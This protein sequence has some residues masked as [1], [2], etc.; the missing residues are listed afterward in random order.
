ME[1]RSAVT[2]ELMRERSEAKQAVEEQLKKITDERDALQ[3]EL[4]RVELLH[5]HELEV[6]RVSVKRAADAVQEQYDRGFVNGLK[7][8]AEAYS[9]SPQKNGDDQRN[10]VK[11]R[12]SLEEAA[13]LEDGEEAKE[14]VLVVVLE[15]LVN[16]PN[17]YTSMR[18]GWTKE[19]IANGDMQLYCPLLSK[20]AVISL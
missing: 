18:K 5:T 2:A 9:S 1:L 14:E 16:A 11:K 7:Q 17:G 3:A 15:R 4:R 20:D 13:V 8:A 6:L 10:G 12:L 19:E